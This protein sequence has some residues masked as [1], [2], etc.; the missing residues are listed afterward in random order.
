MTRYKDSVSTKIEVDRGK[1]YRAN[2]PIMF[3]ELFLP[4]KTAANRRAAFLAIIRELKNHPQKQLASTNHIAEEYG[5]S[6]SCVT[7]TRVM[8]ARMGIIRKRES[9]WRFSSVFKNTLDRLIE[10]LDA[11][12]QPAADADA[13]RREKL[14]IE[15]AK[16]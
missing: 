2:D 16:R 9:Y 10:L 8:M 12:K 15:M 1:V 6:Q 13:R 11:Y 3:A 14:F 7:K 5:L 4:Q